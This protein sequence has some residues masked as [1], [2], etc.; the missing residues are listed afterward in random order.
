MTADFFFKTNPFMNTI[1]VSNSLDPDHAQHFVRPDLSPNCLPYSVPFHLDLHKER[2]G[3]VVECLTQD[4][5]ATGS[6]LIGVT[7]LWSL[8][9]TH[10]S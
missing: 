10:L 4:L 3:S 5:G 9:K 7:A 1:S 6:S 2:S 8:S